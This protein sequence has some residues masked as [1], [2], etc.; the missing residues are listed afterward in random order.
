MNA[1]KDA[2]SIG[3][4]QT[5]LSHRERYLH[6]LLDQLASPLEKRLVGAYLKKSDPV[7]AME[8]ELGDALLEILSRED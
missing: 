1:S 7:K 6:L 8:S 5:P 3:D 2:T 4:N